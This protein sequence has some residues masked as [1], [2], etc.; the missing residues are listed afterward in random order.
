MLYCVLSTQG[1]VQGQHVAGPDG[2]AGPELQND[3]AW[4][5]KAPPG[6]RRLPQLSCKTTRG[7]VL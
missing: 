2:P 4:R 3:V 1:L 6:G 5:F 7:D